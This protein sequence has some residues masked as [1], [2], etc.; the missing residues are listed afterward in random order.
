MRR[1]YLLDAQPDLFGNWSFVREW[2]RIGSLGRV[3]I[4]PYPT[5]QEAQAAPNR[6]RHVKERKGLC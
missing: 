1:F 6:Q 4:D 3:R 2:G 5:P